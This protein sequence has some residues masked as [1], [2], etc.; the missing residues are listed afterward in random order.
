MPSL[1][2]RSGQNIIGQSSVTI[3]RGEG[4]INPEGVVDSFEL[5]PGMRVADF[6]CG[7]GYF[8]LL[9]AKKVSPSGTVTALDILESVLEVVRAKAAAAGLN[10]LQTVRANLEVSGSSGLSDNSQDLALVANVLFQSEK[11]LEI[12]REAR[13]VLVSGGFLVVI[14][15]KK[16]GRGLGP[17]AEHRLDS[18]EIKSL[19]LGMGYSFVKEID[20]GA[21]HFGLMF[22]S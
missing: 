8:T 13:R 7:S 15:W 22:K 16:E 17:P 2:F 9:M 19:A 14:E 18:G 12:L 4:F 1:T 5:K 21:Y 3:S 20:A 10:N 11:R 6:G